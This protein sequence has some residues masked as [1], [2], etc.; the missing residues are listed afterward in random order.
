MLSVATRHVA[1]CHC[2][3]LGNL[4]FE[5]LNVSNLGE[6]GEGSAVHNADSLAVAAS[7]LRVDAAALG[8]ALTSRTVSAGSRSKDAEVLT[9]RMRPSQAADTRDALAKGLYSRMFGWLV[10][11][12]NDLVS[13]PAAAVDLGIAALDI[14]GF[15]QFVCNSFEQLC[16]NYANEKLQQLFISHTITAEQ[17]AYIAEGIPWDGIDYPDNVEIVALLE[18]RSAPNIGLLALMD[19]ECRLQNGSDTSL[20]DKVR[21]QIANNP[22]QKHLLTIPRSNAQFVIVHFAGTV[23]YEA[24]GFLEKNRDPFIHDDLSRCLRTSSCALIRAL[25]DASERRD[26]KLPIGSRPSV[27][28]APDTFT[29]ARTFRAQLGDLVARLQAASMHYVRCVRPNALKRPSFVE[30]AEVLSQLRCSGVLESLKIRKAGFPMRLT[31]EDVFT[32]FKWLLSPAQLNAAS[33]HADP[34]L[35]AHSLLRALLP[36][37]SWQLGRSKAFLKTSHQ[38]NLEELEAAKLA[39]AAAVIRRFARFWYQRNLYRR[40]R[41]SAVLIVATVRRKLATDAYARWACAAKLLVIMLE[42][43]LR[44]AALMR[45]RSAA[46]PLQAL[47]RRV[48]AARHWNALQVEALGAA[49]R[50]AACT[51][52]RVTIA[53]LIRSQYVNRKLMRVEEAKLLQ[54]CM[55]AFQTRSW[56]AR[57]AGGYQLAV[58]RLVANAD[59]RRFVAQR[60]SAIVTQRFLRAYLARRTLAFQ[61]ELERR[62]QEEDAERARLERIQ[63]QENRLAVLTA[64]ANTAELRLARL[65]EQAALIECQAAEMELEMKR[66]HEQELVSTKNLWEAKSAISAVR[67]S[68]CHST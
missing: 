15:E 32:R 2:R 59:R 45:Q 28:A 1:R 52:Q 9:I 13:A 63:E 37:A 18:S 34:K 48:L 58:G 24:A 33:A 51:L 67:Y 20:L 57:R 49:A 47:F 29:V 3:R 41:A 17:D 25:V 7:L 22:A 53:A 60:S 8:R 19:E 61:L 50:A 35:R 62:R 55:R 54:A 10:G 12:I 43:L 6:S 44:H 27:S 31:F 11:R 36:D 56:Y 38:H 26:A 23:C 14:F 68:F 65:N 4:T 64:Q 5:A 21:R 39:F 30:A 66:A 16:I 40:M 42:R 46:V